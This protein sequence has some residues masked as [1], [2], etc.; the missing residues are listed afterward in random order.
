MTFKEE[1]CARPKEPWLPWFVAVEKRKELRTS[2]VFVRWGPMGGYSANL[3]DTESSY[4]FYCEG[5]SQAEVIYARMKYLEME[6]KSAMTKEEIGKKRSSKNPFLLMKDEMLAG[7]RQWDQRLKTPEYYL[8]DMVEVHVYQWWVRFTCMPMF[9]EIEG[10][11]V[12]WH[13]LEFASGAAEVAIMFDGAVKKMADGG[14]YTCAF[15]SLQDILKVMQIR[16]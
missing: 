3:Y 5:R 9:V 16:F 15:E 8:E 6:A 4:H 2:K 7:M 13:D 1:R 14:S 12:C 11:I 10:D